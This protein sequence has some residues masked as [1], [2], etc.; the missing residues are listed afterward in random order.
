[1]RRLVLEVLGVVVV[2]VV[3]GCMPVRYRFRV[4]YD[5]TSFAGWQ[6]QPRCR[7]VQGTIEACLARRFGGTRVPIMGASRTD[8]GVHARGQ[9]AHADLPTHVDCDKLEHSLN[10]MLPADVRVFDVEP[11]PPPAPWQAERSLP[12]HAIMNATGKRYIYRLRASRHP[13]DPM[14]RLYRATVSHRPMDFARFEAALDLFV[15]EHDF[16]A[17]TN[18]PRNYDP[19]ETNRGTVRRINSIQLFDEGCGDASVVVDLDGALYKMIRNIVGTA[20]NIV[21]DTSSSRGALTL[22]DIPR[23]LQ[24]DV[25]RSNN[26]GKPAPAHGLTLDTVYYD[27]DEQHPAATALSRNAP[28]SEYSARNHPGALSSTFLLSSSSSSSSSSSTPPPSD[29]PPW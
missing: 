17:F 24:G 13:I 18:N 3:E 23:L 6:L 4:A 27:D 26:Q 12:W 21:S 20:V 29:R 10:R 2:V 14:R 28:W 1:M 19:L 11:A 9:M 15:G 7:T 5:G 16:R 25:D 8:S 22:D